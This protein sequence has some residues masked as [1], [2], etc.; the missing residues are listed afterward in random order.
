M[1]ILFSGNTAWGMYNFRRFIFESFIQKGNQVIVVTPEDKKYQKE[2][3]RIGC[4]C[5]SIPINAKGKNPLYD[6]LTY[7]KYYKILKKEKPDFCF[8]YTIKPN[9]YGSMAAGKLNI[10]FIPITTGLGY[11][12]L[13][14]NIISKIAKILYKKAF[15]KANEVWFLN[16]EDVQS[17]QQEKIVMG[18]KLFLLHG[19]GIPTEHFE[20]QPFTENT[21]S[22]FLLSARM[23]WDKGVKEFV[24]AAR[25]IKQK[26]PSTKFQLLGF[27]DNKNPK[28]IPLKQIQAWEK[29]GYVEYLGSTNDVRP[30]IYKSTCIVLPSYYREGIPFSLLEGAA[31]GK[32]LITTDNIGCRDVVENGKNGFLCRI[33]DPYDLASC[34]ERIINMPIDKLNEMGLYGRKKVEQEYD[35]HLVIEEYHKRIIPNKI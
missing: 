26:Y 31:C 6:F 25:I 20:Y 32:P 34:M 11:T 35:I 27:V 10:P 13:H 17:F 7:L 24:E 30:Y 3:N 18:K 15:K 2:L 12:F 22:I 8:F 28:T 5:I 23:L 1:K 4:Q 14:K 19:E 16:N 33:K 9:I 21:E 29:E